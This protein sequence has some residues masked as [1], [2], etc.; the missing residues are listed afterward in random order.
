MW[1]WKY[2]ENEVDGL[3][4]AVLTQGRDSVFVWL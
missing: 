2:T 1:T 4:G 3:R